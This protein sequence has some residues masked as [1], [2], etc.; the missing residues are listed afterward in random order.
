MRGAGGSASSLSSTQVRPGLPGAPASSLAAVATRGRPRLGPLQVWREA[1]ARPP[2][3]GP[4]GGRC[5][6]GP[7]SGGTAPRTST[8]GRALCAGASATPR[9]HQS[10]TYSGLSRKGREASPRARGGVAGLLD[11]RRSVSSYPWPRAKP[12][13]EAPLFPRGRSPRHSRAGSSPGVASLLRGLGPSPAFFSGCPR[14][15]EW[16]PA[17]QRRASSFLLPSKCR[18]PHAEL[19]PLGDAGSHELSASHPQCSPGGRHDFEVTCASPR[20]PLPLPRP[21]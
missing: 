3:P 14:A 16:H 4:G 10:P 19:T 9:I 17:L 1:A 21:G 2:R 7:A 13:A 12:T 6:P 11:S 8:P 18:S 15:C 20:C 5:G